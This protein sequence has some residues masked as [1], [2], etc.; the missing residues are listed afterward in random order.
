MLV[1]TVVLAGPG[2][3]AVTDVNGACVAAPWQRPSAPMQQRW[4]KR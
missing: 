2:S 3:G 4:W 1:V